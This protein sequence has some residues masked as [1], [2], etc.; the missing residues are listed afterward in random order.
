MHTVDTI[1]YLFYAV[2]GFLF[3]GVLFSYHIPKLLLGID[4]RKLSEDGNPGTFNAFKYAGVPVGIACLCC[5]LAK[6]FI[7]VWLASSRLGI[8]NALIELVMVAPPLGHACAPFYKG[9]GGKAIA[10]SF[11]ALLGLVPQSYVVVVLIVL[12]V[13]FSTVVVINPNERRSILC[14]GLLAVFTAIG[15]LFTGRW[16]IAL[17]TA[18]ISAVVIYKNRPLPKAPREP[19]PVE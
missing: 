7:P 6:G 19:A 16:R 18:C 12:Y 8:D 3:G 17:G 10:A 1:R 2:F 15:S 4:T 5:D 9:D 14:F 11:G 13:F